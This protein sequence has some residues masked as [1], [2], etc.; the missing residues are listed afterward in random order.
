MTISL[1][2]KIG[3]QA[4]V[5]LC[6]K[7]MTPLGPTWSCWLGT[8]TFC[9]L[10][11]LLSLVQDFSKLRIIVLASF[12]AGHLVGI[13]PAVLL[14]HLAYKKALTE[15]IFSFAK[16]CLQF[17]ESV[18]YY[19]RYIF[20]EIQHFSFILILLV[21]LPVFLRPHAVH[22]PPRLPLTWQT[23][24]FHLAVVRLPSALTSFAEKIQKTWN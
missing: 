3:F 1:S 10:L 2:D 7:S 23:L 6:H 19:V 24:K 11:L 8:V 4:T 21:R 13:F 15:L 22:C 16:L 5:L 9:H 20:L 17:T 14:G 12:P 18:L